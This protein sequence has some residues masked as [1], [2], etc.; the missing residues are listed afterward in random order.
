MTVEVSLEAEASPADQAAVAG[1]FESAD[2]QADVR[3]DYIRRSADL[4]PWLIVIGVVAARFLWAAVGGAGDEAGRDAWKGL[5]WLVN[6]LYEARRP[7]QSPQGGV[8]ISDQ[9]ARSRSSFRLTFPTW[10]TS[11]SCICAP[12]REGAERGRSMGHVRLYCLQCE[13]EGRRA[14]FYEPATT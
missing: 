3:A 14:T 13:A 11:A 8:S 6:A 7:S 12:A 5:K 9:E 10:R 4:L 1:V 2:I